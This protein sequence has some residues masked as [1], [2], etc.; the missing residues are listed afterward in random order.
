M[1]KYAIFAGLGLELVGITA[2]SLWIGQKLEKT[3]P[4]QGLFVVICLM[5][6]FSG[7][8]VRIILSLRKLTGKD[9]K[10]T[11]KNLAD[12]ETKL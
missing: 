6:G 3:Y 1:K 12:D 7:W 8:V 11:E 5:L 9:P 4:M 10:N 2:V